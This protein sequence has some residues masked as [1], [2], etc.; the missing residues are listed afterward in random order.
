M[1]HT[2]IT[3]NKAD[4]YPI[5]KLICVEKDLIICAVESH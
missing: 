3:E 4:E 1:F 2:E 5:N